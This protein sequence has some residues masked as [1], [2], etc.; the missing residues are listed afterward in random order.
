MK[1]NTSPTQ[2]EINA[3]YTARRIASAMLESLVPMAF[4]D[5]TATLRSLWDAVQADYDATHGMPVERAECLGRRDALKH[6]ANRR[7]WH[8]CW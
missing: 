4:A 7:G 5:G 6:E 2:T 8:M 1:T 3:F